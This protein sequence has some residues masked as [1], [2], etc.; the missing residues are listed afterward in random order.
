MH[1]ITY[2][3]VLQTRGLLEQSSVEIPDTWQHRPKEWVSTFNHVDPNTIVLL[4][5]TT[6][7]KDLI[8]ILNQHTAS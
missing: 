4:T 5:P 7:V 8:L 1:T 2:T 6:Q 3:L